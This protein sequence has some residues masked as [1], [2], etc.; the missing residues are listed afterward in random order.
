MGTLRTCLCGPPLLMSQLPLPPPPPPPPQPKANPAGLVGWE[1]REEH[2]P[3]LMGDSWPT[4]SCPGGRQTGQAA[5]PNKG[6]DFDPH[7]WAALATASEAT[8]TQAPAPLGE[9]RN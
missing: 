4:A 9:P 5:R 1:S 8:L 3:C 2:G 6:R 7:R